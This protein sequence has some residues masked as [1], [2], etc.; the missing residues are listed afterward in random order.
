MNEEIKI[1]KQVIEKEANALIHLSQSLGEDFKKA[2]DLIREISGKIVVTGIGKSGHIGRKISATLSS[3]GK[4]SYYLHP[5]EAAHGD[6][7]TIGNTDCVLAISNSG[8]T[9]E[10]IPVLDYCKRYGV[11]IIGITGNK[12]SMLGE[13]ANV[14]LVLPKYEEACPIGLVPTTSTTMCLALGDAIAVAVYQEGFSKQIF[15]EFHPGGKL[16]YKLLKVAHIMHT[17][18]EMPVIPITAN[19]GDA[20][21]E[22][23]RKALG[24]VG[25]IDQ[26]VLVGIIT[27]GDLRRH[28]HQIPIKSSVAEIMTRRPKTTTPSTLA[29]EAL[30]Y[31]TDTK[32]SSL[33]VVDENVPIGVIHLHD[34]LRIGADK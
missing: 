5:S 29:V 18:E 4:A 7:G 8:E 27:D 14:L 2:V 6:L 25:I 26:G 21:L 23:T 15:A 31:M 9:H 33:F 1:G 20:I 12:K 24:C 30:K 16:G 32:I 17:D 11:Q 28:I 34:C 3:T 13:Y 19:I 22:I 10:L